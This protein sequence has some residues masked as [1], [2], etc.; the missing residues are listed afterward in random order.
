[1]EAFDCDNK[2]NAANKKVANSFRG[3]HFSIQ[4][5]DKHNHV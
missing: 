2:L 4:N 1:M 5:P 3:S